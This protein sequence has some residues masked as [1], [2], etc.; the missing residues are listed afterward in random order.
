MQYTALFDEGRL[1]ELY[2]T[3]RDTGKLLRAPAKYL[4]DMNRPLLRALQELLGKDN[5][6]YFGP[7]S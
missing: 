5:V 3:F 7:K 2:L 1:S 6:A 4:V